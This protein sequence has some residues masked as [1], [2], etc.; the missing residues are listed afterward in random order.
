[1]AQ[2]YTVLARRGN[3]IPLTFTP[4]E[5]SPQPSSVVF[6]PEASSLIANILSDPDARSLEFGAGL[7]FPVETAVKT[8]TSSD[9]RDAWAIG[10][11]YA[12]TVAVWMG[13]LND[14]PMNGVTGSSGPATVLRS[15]FAQ[16]NRSQ[17]T[18]GLWLSPK[19]V[20]ADICRRDGRPADGHCQSVPEWFVPGTV[21][22]GP[23]VPRAPTVDYKVV[24]PT[25]GLQLARDPRIPKELQ[26]FTMSVAPVPSLQ[27]VTWYVDGEAASTTTAGKFSWPL[28]RGTHE[29]YAVIRSS[30]SRDP[31]TTEKVRFY[32]R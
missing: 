32:V 13:N 12:H 7:Q 15:V 9:Y 30:G 1:M 16:L 21:P 3:L 25:P 5:A 17:D 28:A 20:A 27:A 8:G 29:M 10:F 2:A 31:H 4:R 24:E 14:I 22:E 18:R 23:Q 6:T 19:L 26:A 11:D